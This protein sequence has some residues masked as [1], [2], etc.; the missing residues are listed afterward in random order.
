MASI[1]NSWGIANGEKRKT[2]LKVGSD[3]LTD[4]RI[5]L[6]IV[7]GRE[8]GPSICISAGVHGAEYAGIRAASMLFNQLDPLKLHGT[9][10]IIPVANP[11][12]FARVSRFICPIDN[13]NL[14]KVFPGNKDGS[15][16]ERI[17]FSIFDKVI[18][19]SNYVIDL[20]GGDLFEK[21]LQH[22]LFF[23]TGNREVDEASRM[24][25]MTFTERFYYPVSPHERPAGGELSVEAAKRGIPSIWSEAGSEGR[26]DKN[27]AECDIKFHRNGILNVLGYLGMIT[28]ENVSHRSEYQEVTKQVWLKANHGGFFIPEISSGDIINKNASLGEI[29]DINDNV[30]EI[31]ICPIDNAIVRLLYTT[32]VV[33]TGDPIIVLWQTKATSLSK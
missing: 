11:I 13:L 10:A 32:G 19:H 7:S 23:L 21:M 22:T 33:N 29:R 25:A 5:P 3:P 14:H 6:W 26:L 2:W 20:H 28:N 17:A 24:L 27:E 18:I 31:L 8:D 30:L 4:I 1:S 9:V 16:T 15:I 12:S